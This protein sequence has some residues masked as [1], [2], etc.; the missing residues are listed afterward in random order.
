MLNYD[1][2]PGESPGTSIDITVPS[3]EIDNPPYTY[4]ST[5]FT[6]FS[7]KTYDSSYAIVDKLEFDLIIIKGTFSSKSLTK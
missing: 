5:I 6:G 4:D 7:C 1:G 2:S 3:G